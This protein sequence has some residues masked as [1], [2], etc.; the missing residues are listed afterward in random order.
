M[1]AAPV[2]PDVAGRPDEAR[3]LRDTL[4]GIGL[5]QRE[6]KMRASQLWNWIYHNGV[7]NFERM[8]NI[9]KGFRQKL[10]DTFLLD[11]PEIVTEQV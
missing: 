9:Q 8:T 3:S 10:A 7:T 11:R 5:D 6:A 1:P 2:R 4:M